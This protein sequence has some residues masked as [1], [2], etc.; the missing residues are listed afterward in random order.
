MPFRRIE[1]NKTKGTPVLWSR[2]LHSLALYARTGVY[3][4]QV[5]AL[6]HLGLVET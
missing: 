6:D 4:V 3:M 1:T 5:Y 2:H